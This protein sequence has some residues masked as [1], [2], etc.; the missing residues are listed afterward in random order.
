MFWEHGQQYVYRKAIILKLVT[1][2]DFWLVEKKSS[3]YWLVHTNDNVFAETLNLATFEIARQ[4]QSAV[5]WS[6][7]QPIDK[8]GVMHLWCANLVVLVCAGSQLN[9]HFNMWFYFP[10]RYMK[11]VNF[12]VPLYSAG[13]VMIIGCIFIPRF[14][15]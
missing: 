8:R 12:H 3:L 13:E 14:Y 2:I 15:R 9:V 1:H 11:F 4:S 6:S 5:W 10:V 7:F